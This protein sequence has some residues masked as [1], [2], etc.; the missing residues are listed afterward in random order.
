MR[1][2]QAVHRGTWQRHAKQ[3]ISAMPLERAHS[4]RMPE[5][6]KPSV[7]RWSA[8][9]GNDAT[10]FVVG[11]YG[12]QGDTAEALSTSPFAVWK[13]AV[14]AQAGGPEAH[15]MVQF[16]DGGGKCNWVLI[17]YWPTVDRFNVWRSDPSNAAFWENPARLSEP[18]GYFREEL[19]VKA[20]RY[21]TIY[22]VDFRGGISRSPEVRLEK[23][24]ESSYWGAARDRIP[25]AACDRLESS[26]ATSLCTTSRPT[27]G[28]RF[29]VF[30]PNNLAIIRS[31]QY[32]ER[33][34]EDQ[35][36]DEIKRMRP[37]FEAGLEFLANHPIDT[38]CCVL[39]YMRHFDERGRLNSESAV[40]GIF[41]SLADLERWTQD[42]ASHKAIY[43]E[44]FRQLM[45]YKE[46]RELRTWHE[47]FVF[48]SKGQHFEYLICHPRTG[49]LPYFDARRI[50]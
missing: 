12:V 1:G 24:F 19:R 35:R 16:V 21:E 17:A 26:A 6:F 9:F 18:T 15:D 32:W 45:L 47:V 43:A 31:G 48:D 25:R 27:E 42:H 29:V 46:R 40:H 3:K 20:D 14:L 5:G 36:A 49:L 38:G 44:A 11:Y 30:P 39:R 13:D 22:F 4:M 33:S 41:Q 10:D 34:G 23:T 7:Q 50:V 8:R 28:A 37:R 2:L